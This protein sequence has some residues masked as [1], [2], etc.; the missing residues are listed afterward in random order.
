MSIYVPPSKDAPLVSNDIVVDGKTIEA[1]IFGI[2]ERISV[3]CKR[4]G[5]SAADVKLVAVTKFN[6]VEAV[7]SAHNAGARCFGENR[8]QEAE[9]KFSR[10]AEKYP[11]IELHLLG[12]LQGNK[13]KKAIVI[14][15]CVQSVDTEKIVMELS[16]R[17][18]DEDTSI[19]I[20]YEL[21]TGEE[22]KS[23][24]SSPDLLFS[25]IEK[26]CMLPGIRARGL[27]TMAPYTDDEKAIRASF[28]TCANAFNKARHLFSLDAFDILSMG[29][30]NDFEIAV[31]E[32]STMVRIGTGIFGKRV[33]A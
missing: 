21:H 16:R 23:G 30:T 2:K 22:S 31:E 12:H 20:L 6:T 27:M 14:F 7:I 25:A 9:G 28:R 1:A 5:R 26:T 4:A 32:G 13:V 29:M 24:F 8:V 10:L 11:D 3:A 15:N 33:Y 17:C 19:D 18:K